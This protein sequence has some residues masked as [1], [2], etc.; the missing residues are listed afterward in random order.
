ML[1]NLC[2]LAFVAAFLALGVV[3]EVRSVVERRLAATAG[4]IT[5]VEET[6]HFEWTATTLTAEESLELIF[7][8]G[9]GWA[10][11][12]FSEGGCS[13]GKVMTR[14]VVAA[15]VEK[16]LLG[17]KNPFPKEGKV[18]VPW[19]MEAGLGDQLGHQQYVG[20]TRRQVCFITAKA[21]LGAGTEA[22][23]N[24]LTRILQRTVPHCVPP[25]PSVR[26]A[27]RP[28]PSALTGDFGMT[29]WH[30]LAACAADPTL[31]DGAQGPVVLVAKGSKPA[32]VSEVRERGQDTPMRAS[33]LA[34]C[35]YD[36]GDAGPMAGGALEAMR[37]EVCTPPTIGAPGRDFMTGGI[38]RVRGQA[39]QDISAQFLGG[40]VFGN[41]CGLG[42]GQDERLMTY[43]PEV[44]V[45]SFFLS[46]D[47]EHP[48]LRQPAWI[49]GAR[50]LLIGLDGTARFNTRLELDMAVP[51]TS[52]LVEV[53]IDGKH[54]QVS[55]SAPFLAFMSENQDFLDEGA[56]WRGEASAEE[57]HGKLVLARRNRHPLQRAVRPDVWYSFMYQ[58]R[59]WYSAV[60]LTSYSGEVQTA[61]RATVKSLGTGPFLAGLWWGDSQL[62]FLAVWIAHAI[63]AGTWGVAS[64]PL[65]YYI[66]AD[67]TENPGNQCFVHS[68][69]NCRRCLERCAAEPL[70]P[71]SFWLPEYGFMGPG[72]N[73]SCVVDSADY[74]GQKGIEHIL[75]TFADAK[76][77]KLWEA[78]EEVLRRGP[79]TEASVFDLLLARQN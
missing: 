78:V 33:R 48:Q 18:P 79:Q 54:Y 36:D 77:S 70:P 45:L 57:L 28:D 41:A 30:L 47:G 4:L 15:W 16:E 8:K 58:V 20:Y 31:L 55:S 9:A 62:G 1:S 21:L 25:A 60:A 67:F 17:G 59:A 40:Y 22:Y 39:M 74:C 68:Q 11:A 75:A 10:N 13:S 43:L 71:T 42:G 14:P 19:P 5:N 52:D 72:G 65:E 66:Y 24:G 69:E 27:G 34:V 29:M 32:N 35:R 23:S 76:A 2:H 51:F 50:M 7:P 6:K 37:P 56:Y 64:L 44:F 26:Q 61:L 3:A 73:K 38:S 12:C 49:L 63:A 53:S 46:Q